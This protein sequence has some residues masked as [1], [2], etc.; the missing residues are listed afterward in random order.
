M[1]TGRNIIKLEV[2]RAIKCDINV[3]EVRG[4]LNEPIS[5]MR[6]LRMRYGYDTK[7]MSSRAICRVG[8]DRF[9]TVTVYYI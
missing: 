3:N 8:K 1:T 2:P 5:D 9:D 4:L 6:L 7:G